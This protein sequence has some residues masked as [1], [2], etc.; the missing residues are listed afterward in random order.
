[1]PS[2]RSRSKERERKRKKRADLSAEDKILEQEKARNR[3]IKRRQN[4]NDADKEAF[5]AKFRKGMQKLRERKESREKD[6]VNPLWPAGLLY[7]ETPQ[8]KRDREHQ[9]QKTQ[10]RR[11][12]LTIHEKNREKEERNER[13]RKLR[14]NQTAEDKIVENE[15]KKER[16]RKLRERREKEKCNVDSESP[17][18]KDIVSRLNSK[19]R[20]D[21]E[22]RKI[23]EEMTSDDEKCVCDIDI[24]CEYC[25]KV[26]E[27][28]KNLVHIISPEE[29]KQLEKEELEQN[30][31]M[32]RNKKRSQRKRI[33]EKFLKPLPPLPEKELS[34]YEKIRLEII[35]QRNKEW[36]KFEQEWEEKNK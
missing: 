24:N 11:E 14:G 17:R 22:R 29:K 34:Q 18:S 4:M 1:M 6:P 36:L 32:Q 23:V 16:M 20:E 13:M 7:G 28:E 8:Y 10:Q 33:K 19:F 27:K 15:K 9:K 30:K 3:M 25:E 2:K 21:I 26:Y 31:I 35:S 5:K 12:N